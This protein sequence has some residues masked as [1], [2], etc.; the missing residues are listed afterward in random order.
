MFWPNSNGNG[1]GTLSFA[2]N[3]D[4][5]TYMWIDGVQKLNN[6]AWNVAT[7]TG[8][9]T[10]PTGWHDVDIRF[11]N[12]GGGA[13][14]NNS[15]AGWTA[16]KGF[17]YRIDKDPN[18]GSAGADDPAASSV[19]GNDYIVPTDNGSGNLFRTAVSGNSLIK[20][21]A[22]TLTL[23][24]AN[25]IN[26]NISITGGILV[27]ETLATLGTVPKIETTGGSLGLPAA[28]G[29]TLPASIA[30][31]LKGPGANNAGG[32]LNLG[33]N[34]TVTSPITLASDASIGSN[35]GTLTVN[36]ASVN[37][38]GYALTVT[39]S[40]DTTISAPITSLSVVPGLFVGQN[41]TANDGNFANGPNAS[42]GFDVDLTPTMG[43]KSGN[44]AAVGQSTA[45]GWATNNTWFYKG[46][47]FWPNSNGDGTGTLQFAENVDDS[48]YM[49][50]DGAQKMSNGAWNVATTS[51]PVTLPTG[52]HDIE[53]RFGNGGGGAGANNS[54]PGW[55]A[56]KGFGYRVNDANSDPTDVNGANYSIPTDNG[57]GNLFRNATLVSGNA[58]VKTGTGTLNLT[59]ANTLT[60]NIA[61]NGG[62]LAPS[63]VAALG[64]TPVI[65]TDGGS[66]G[67][68]A[69]GGFTLPASIAVKLGGAGANSA[70][71][72]LNLG[73]A[74]T[75]LSPITLAKDGSIGANAGTLTVSGASV[76]TTSYTLTVTG[77]GDTVISA[78]LSGDVKVP[79]TPGLKVGQTNVNNDSN[80]ASVPNPTYGSD[81]DLGFTM[82]NKAGNDAAVAQT[83]AKTWATNNTWF[84]KGQM[85]WPNSNGNGTGT[86][87]FA[88]NV[89]DS[90]FMWVD[91][92]QKLN[93]TTWNTP[94]SSGAITLPTGWHDIEV[95]FSN[96]GGGAGP[97]VVNSWTTTKGFG[98]R[99]DKDPVAGGSNGG[100][101]PLASSIQGND[102]TILV[103]NGTGNTFRT[104]FVANDDSLLKTGTGT[105]TLSGANTSP[106]GTSFN[107]VVGA[108]SNQIKVI[109]P[110]NL[111]SGT[112][113]I[114]PS[115][116]LPTGSTSLTLINN[117]STDAVTGTFTGLAEGG[118]VTAGTNSYTI[119]Y[120]GG[121]GNDVVLTPAASAAT[122]TTLTATPL[123]T[124]GGS[125]VQFTAV[126]APSPVA[127]GTVT[128]LDNGVA[129]PGGS[130]VALTNGQA[131]F[132]T[133]TLAVG[134]HPVTAAYIG[135]TGFAASTS[136]PQTVVISSGTGGAP[137]VNTVTLNGGLAAFSGAQHSRVINAAVEFNQAVTLDPGAMTLILHAK[138][139]NYAG[140][141][142]GTGQPTGAAVPAFSV[143]PSADNKTW[144]MTWS[145]ANT[146]VGAD[147]LASLKDG[148]YD[149]VI[150]ATKVHPVGAPGT[151]MAANSTTVIHR[152]YG[153]NGAPTATGSDFSSI[154][155][156]GDNLQF[157][158][159]FNKPAG[160]G[161]VPYFDINGDG[162][163]NTFDNL[164]FRQ[165]FN[166]AL[167]W[168]V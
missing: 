12:G 113:Q 157:R 50:V 11:G 125:S 76:N 126:V 128:F 107:V 17:G 80:L 112:L 43:N 23:S 97:N 167:T 139:V 53:I 55:S 44:D 68:P 74:N 101:D 47:M 32:V 82:G 3:V 153:D 41:N 161:Y 94:S 38:S 109:G 143:A 105:L 110:V 85:F 111:S 164:Q 138:N 137:A 77:A 103:D 88:E 95:R 117:D 60:R 40:G 79:A 63:N 16:S 1:T 149:L 108:Q 8:P 96:G 127:L 132:S 87:S 62:L 9:V 49:W 151:N 70:G 166:K 163:I 134:N 93:N 37:V 10:L 18:N 57:S 46:Q 99:I 122:T 91:G 71:A 7:T 65:S 135:A 119:S 159:A 39:G 118:T 6:E 148:V 61:I 51:G 19:D 69:A 147:Q 20:T 123:A 33:G 158:G 154:V 31:S 133:T 115:F 168:S 129:I 145:G 34:N 54:Q 81:V 35:A 73:G 146:D 42:F 30:L 144:T 98:Y 24:A 83:T 86:L 150:D 92:V 102:Y 66:L 27:P 45:K 13:G 25:T 114:A 104:A 116:T 21:G 121:D 131:V 67:L 78:P 29:F 141:S 100:A 15:Q 120:K 5:N 64:G 89:D 48:V 156:T 136:A 84:Y 160:G 58:L 130:N 152:L 28:G 106:R 52:W 26:R 4:D 56:S 22:G 140:N 124:T 90:V 75:V 72:I 2:E 162:I 36:S 59:G 165:R 142:G 14:A 155:N